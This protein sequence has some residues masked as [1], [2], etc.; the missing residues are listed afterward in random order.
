[1]KLY[2]TLIN[3]VTC[4]I[5]DTTD[6]YV[7][8]KYNKKYW[9]ATA[10]KADRLTYSTWDYCDPEKCPNQG[11]FEG[12]ALIKLICYVCP[13][14][15]LTEKEG[16]YSLPFHP[17]KVVYFTYTSSCIWPSLLFDSWFKRSVYI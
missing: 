7:C 17:G 10:L 11:T 16:A 8:A 1:M 6:H 3:P 9:C 2:K 5:T 13:D 14:T 15:S 12:L 4:Y